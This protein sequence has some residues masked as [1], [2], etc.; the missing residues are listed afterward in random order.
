MP[1]GPWPGVELGGGYG[2]ITVLPPTGGTVDDAPKINAAM[3]AGAA[4]GGSSIYLQRGSYLIKSLI[5]YP[6]NRLRLRGQGPGV[7]RLVFDDAT[8]LAKWIRIHNRYACSLEDLT[9]TSNSAVA[10]A[11][12]VALSIEGG[13]ATVIFNSVPTAMHVVRNVELLKQCSGVQIIDGAGAIPAWIVAIQGAMQTWQ[14][15][16]GGI[17]LLINSTGGIH[18]VSDV[19]ATKVDGAAAPLYQLRIRATQDCDISRWSSTFGTD[20]LKID[21]DAGQEVTALNIRGCRFDSVTNYSGHIIPNV[22][23][24]H[25]RQLN[26]I[27]SWFA[28]NVAGLVIDGTPTRSVAIRGCEFYRSS[29]VGILLQST[30]AAGT[31]TQIDNN[32]IATASVGIAAANAAHD[33]SIR[34]ND[35][36]IEYGETAAFGLQLALGCVDFIATG[37]NLRLAATPL[38]DLSGAVNKVVANNI[39]V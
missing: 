2:S 9:L 10:L 24:A 15:S 31:Q 7:T 36:V 32:R 25:C 19:F 30:G 12:G 20:G 23:A 3:A 17:P 28:S 6:G 33:F 1:W 35:I 21:P 18:Y 34:N 38:Q 11:S 5:D 37:N 4:L 39:I 8:A 16:N 29:I 27:D 26:V 14:C 22:A 13:D